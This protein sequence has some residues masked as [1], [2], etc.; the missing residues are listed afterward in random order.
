MLKQG[1]DIGQNYNKERGILMKQ[2]IISALLCMAVFVS[3]IPTISFADTLEYYPD[4]TIPK[5][6]AGE[7]VLEDEYKNSRTYSYKT[8]EED[9]EAYIDLIEALG[10]N[11]IRT[12]GETKTYQ[13]E[14][15]TFG[16]RY[17]SS[18]LEDRIS[19]QY[20]PKVSV[21][22]IT[23]D[24]DTIKLK[25]GNTVT[26]Q[27]TI[28]PSNASVKVVNWSS[29][30]E[31]VATVTSKG[32]V[33]AKSAGETTITVETQDG[34]LKAYCTI[35]VT[36]ET[37][38]A[39]EIEYYPGTKIPTYSSVA[40]VRYGTV[41]K[42]IQEHED[43]DTITCAYD[44]DTK[45]FDSY[46]TALLEEGFKLYKTDTDMDGITYYYERADQGLVGVKGVYSLSQP[47]CFISYMTNYKPATNVTGI[48]LNESRITL[49]EGDRDILVAH[50]SPSNA[51]NKDVE[52]TSSDTRIATVSHLGVVRAISAG[53]AT[54]TAT[55]SDGGF[56]ADCIVIVEKEEKDD[57]DDDRP[58]GNGASR[59]T[60]GG[61][62]NTGVGEIVAKDIYTIKFE[63]NGGSRVE[64]IRVE[65]YDRAIS[66][67]VPTRDGYIFDGWYKDKALNIPY[68]FTESVT[69]SFTLYAKWR[70]AAETKIILKI[71]STA[72]YVND[73]IIT[74]D[75]APVIIN[76]RTMLPIR[77]ITE[78]LGADVAWIAETNTV[79][80][81]M[82]DIK[83]SLTI[84][85]DFAYVNDQKVS[86]DTPSFVEND[87]TYLPLRFISEKLGADVYWNGETQTVT[88]TK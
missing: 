66:P 28:S 37:Q 55:T 29:S 68:D 87:R 18:L 3:L 79:K 34:G 86:L 17:Y 6:T 13:S 60:G 11:C 48:S 27:A 88:I 24:K 14:N 30:D 10:F 59:P 5:Y 64:D 50:I 12:D 36:D 72:A 58:S 80:I 46:K 19:I 65:E 62:G 20:I 45:E 77:F 56:S 75:V 71:G 47:L 26:L 31:T 42:V 49:E 81:N 38:P 70:A 85:D 41:R 40:L 43:G 25:N 52:W 69:D 63:T 73:D 9:Y 33:T 32:V 44:Y 23:L 21:T 74:N 8:N 4:S 67:A 82:D 2:K 22:G 57:N 78:A 84:G 54:I 16:I 51:A 53:R 1:L 15:Q 39:A 35:E 76:D 61:T 83:I 7:L